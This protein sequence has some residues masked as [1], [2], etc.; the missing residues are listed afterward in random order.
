MNILRP[1]ASDCSVDI[2]TNWIGAVVEAVS[3][4]ENLALKATFIPVNPLQ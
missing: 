3:V 4:R 1:V 2:G